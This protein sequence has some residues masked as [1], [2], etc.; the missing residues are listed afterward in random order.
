MMDFI[1]FA[2]VLAVTLTV[3]QIMGGLLMLNIM[4]SEKFMRNY[5][6]KVKDITEMIIEEMEE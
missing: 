6:K 1:V 5:T 2:L 3:S 4:F